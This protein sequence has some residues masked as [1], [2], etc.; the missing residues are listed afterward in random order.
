MDKQIE[1]SENYTVPKKRTGHSKRTRNRKP[2][3]EKTTQL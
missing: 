1:I 2:V 3:T